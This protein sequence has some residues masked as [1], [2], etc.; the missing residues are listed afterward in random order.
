MKIGAIYQGSGKCSFTV[1][2]PLRNSVALRIVSPMERLIPMNKISG[3]YW[4]LSDVDANPGDRFFYRLDDKL[5]RPDPASNY[6]PENVHGPSEI[7]DHSSFDW[8]DSQWN[9]IALEKMIIYELHVGTFSR[10]GTLD[11]VAEKLDYLLDLGIT[12]IEL[13]PLAQFPGERNWGYDGAYPFAVQSSYGG[14]QALKQLVDQCHCRGLSVILD[15]VYNHL[16]PEGTYVLDYG[17]YFTN[18]YSTPWGDAVNFDGPWSD[19]V[20]NFFIQNALYWFENYH[21]DALRLD[22]VQGIYDFGAKHIL[23]ELAENTERFS[24]ADRKRYL[25]AE[26]DLDD[27]RVITPLRQNGYGIDAQWHDDFHHSL[28]AILTGDKKSYYADF[29][30]MAQLVKAYRD[31]FVYSWTYSEN[32]KRHHGSSSAHIP[33]KQLVVCLQN[34]DQIGNRLL[35]ERLSM[36]ISFEALKLAAGALLT[37]PY[38]PL[39]FMGEEFAADTPFQYFISHYDQDL[40]EAVRKGRAREFAQMHQGNQSPD[41]QDPQTFFRCKLDWG[42]LEAKKH[43]L[44]YQYYRQLINFRK[45]VPAL[46]YLEKKNMEITGFHKE[47]V[48]VLNRWH[49]SSSICAIMNLSDRTVNLC[50]DKIQYPCRKLIDSSEKRWAGEGSLMPQ[51][52]ISK[53]EYQLSPY[54]FVLYE[55]TAVSG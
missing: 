27:V 23:Q 30:E 15:V 37:A 31:G 45:T 21:I 48:L 28:H 10:A 35:G 29:G 3:G 6:Q 33:G 18:Q 40:V 11:G 38:I 55:S 17:A 7:V 26:S 46:K 22:A 25:I 4:H 36:M 54:H 9:G 32:R 50:L 34:H 51:E 20:R 41:P 24:Q 42:S 49:E 39:L 16:G 2:A 44:I 53:K 13:M 12:A 5:D 14:P 1:W 8:H 19:G 52:I 47:K 43:Q